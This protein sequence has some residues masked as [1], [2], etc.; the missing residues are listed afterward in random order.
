VQN[1][2]T[3]KVYLL[4]GTNLGD[5]SN[6]LLVARDRLQ[7]T[8]GKIV[9][10][11]FTYETAAWGNTDQPNFLNEVIELWTL[12][13]PQELLSG[14]HAIEEQMGRYREVKWGPRVIDID[15]LFFSDCIIETENLIVP[16]PALHL[17][18][19]T[20]APLADVARDVVHPIFQK[21]VAELLSE[22]EDPL[23]VAKI[24]L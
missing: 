6:N 21:T 3:N 15:I 8:L 11:S 10:R 22:C 4:L 9:Q 14:I 23:P 18:R 5:R 20:L 13:S 19:F 1:E 16:H 7:I 17:R 2:L 24:Q 12:L